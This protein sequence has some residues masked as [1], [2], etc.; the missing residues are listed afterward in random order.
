MEVRSM[1]DLFFFFFLAFCLISL[2][3]YIYEMIWPAWILLYR[4]G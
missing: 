1:A 2:K 4:P 3:F